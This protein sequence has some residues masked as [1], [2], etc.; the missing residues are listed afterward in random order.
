MFNRTNEKINKTL[1]N[2]YLIDCQIGQEYKK[3]QLSSNILLVSE[4]CFGGDFCVQKFLLLNQG[5]HFIRK[6]FLWKVTLFYPVHPLKGRNCNYQC[7]ILTLLH[8]FYIKCRNC[9]FSYKCHCYH[10]QN[11]T[12]SSFP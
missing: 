5:R 1:G 12:V 10:T 11:L 2:N 3:N 6:I 9:D 8:F 4:I 7:I